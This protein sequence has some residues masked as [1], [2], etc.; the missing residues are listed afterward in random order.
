[1]AGV[2]SLPEETEEGQAREPPP[3]KRAARA[4][5]AAR[6]CAPLK[7]RFAARLCAPLKV[8]FLEDFGEGH[9]S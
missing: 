8:R 1:M 2:G 4:R 3:E 7:V 6:L 5:W 9:K